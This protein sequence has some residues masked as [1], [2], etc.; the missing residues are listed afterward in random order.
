[1]GFFPEYLGADFSAEV[2]IFVSGVAHFFGV[3]PS[4]F[5]GGPGCFRGG[6]W[7][8]W[9]M[10]VKSW[11]SAQSDRA[12]AA[13]KFAAYQGQFGELLCSRGELFHAGTNGFAV[14]GFPVRGASAVVESTAGDARPSVLRIGAGAVLAGPAGAIVGGLL[15]RQPGR[16]YV[17]VTLAD[18]R[19]FV[20]DGPARDE[21]KAREFARKVNLAAAVE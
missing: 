10:G 3:P 15:T 8:T 14:D 19:Q 6:P 9:G 2:P 16:V 7:F 1:M 12:A 11:F 17:I 4:V 5:V 18:G 13:R 21:V 20:G